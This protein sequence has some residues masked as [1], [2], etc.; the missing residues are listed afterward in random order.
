MATTASILRAALA[1]GYS[2]FWRDGVY[3]YAP[4]AHEAQRA[5]WSAPFQ[6]LDTCALAALDAAQG[7]YI[8]PMS[9]TALDLLLLAEARHAQ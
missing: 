2:V 1:Q 7:L 6:D 5:F 3:R 9:R 8:A 4:C